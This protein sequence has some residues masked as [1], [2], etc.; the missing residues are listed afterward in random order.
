MSQSRTAVLKICSFFSFFHLIFNHLNVRTLVLPVMGIAGFWLWLL[1][2]VSEENVVYGGLLIGSL[3][4]FLKKNQEKMESFQWVDHLPLESIIVQGSDSA[5]IASNGTGAGL[6]GLDQRGSSPIRLRELLNG[7]MHSEDWLKFFNNSSGKVSVSLA[8]YSKEYFAVNLSWKQIS[9]EP[10]S[11][12]LCQFSDIQRLSV[13]RFHHFAELDPSDTSERL[14]E[15]LSH[16]PFNILDGILENYPIALCITSP[17]GGFCWHKTPLVE[18]LFGTMFSEN[19]H[20][21]RWWEQ[22]LLPEEA[23]KLS[24]LWKQILID[25]RIETVIRVSRLDRGHSVV[26]WTAIL[27]KDH[28]GNPSLVYHYFSKA[29]EETANEWPVVVDSLE[30]EKSGIAKWSWNRKSGTVKWSDEFYLLHQLSRQEQPD[31]SLP[32][33][34]MSES[35]RFGIKLLLETMSDSLLPF[36]TEYKI[37]LP[38]GST[39]DFVLIVGE[40]VTGENGETDFLSGIIQDVSSDKEQRKLQLELMDELSRHK[41]LIKEFSTALSHRLRV[42]VAQLQGVLSIIL[43]QGGIKRDKQLEYLTECADELDAAIHEMNDLI[44]SD[45]GGDG[46]SE[47]FTWQEI[48]KPIAQEFQE[49]IIDIRASVMVDFSGASKV[50]GIKENLQ[51]I[52]GELLNNSIR[53]RDNS[54]LLELYVHTEIVDSNVWFHIQD[55]GLGIDLNGKEQMAFELYKRFHSDRSGKG[56]GLHLVKVW[57]ESMN[58]EVSMTSIAG[59]GTR[60]S[61]SVPFED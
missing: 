52:L 60:V 53:F 19:S 17:D 3:P 24:A 5:I 10:D 54:R 25:G 16:N 8:S 51:G 9:V 34:Y 6:L 56:F 27:Q 40:V 55:N 4:G 48:W 31:I 32:F 18:E 28:K 38:D 2:D 42:P 13:A 58:G 43:N 50:V 49:K 33:P 12:F 47:S 20:V 1:F 21:P 35:S 59:Q 41:Q 30:K 26:N 29:T 39:K 23:S 11:L 61:F 7:G 37:T 36:S 14:S 45:K 15:S 46:I 44:N 57:I 22:G